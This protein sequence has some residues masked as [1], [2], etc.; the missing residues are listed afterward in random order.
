MWYWGLVYRMHICI[1]VYNYSFIIDSITLLIHSLHGS[2]FSL[3]ETQLHQIETHSATQILPSLTHS[4]QKQP[5][6]KK[7]KNW[8]ERHKN[9]HKFKNF[10]L[11][12]I[13]PLCTGFET[14]VWFWFWFWFRGLGTHAFDKQCKSPRAHGEEFHFLLVSCVMCERNG[15]YIYD[16]GV[17]TVTDL[18]YFV[19]VIYISGFVWCM[20]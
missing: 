20:H 4:I 8:N 19:L 10:S 15:F 11:P 18:I 7:K 3:K 6:K 14:R 2:T 16:A 12:L 1:Y 9:C 13:L 17:L 5:P